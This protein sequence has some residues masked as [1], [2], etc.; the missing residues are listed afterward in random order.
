MTSQNHVVFLNGL[1]QATIVLIG[2]VLRA[3]DD[4]IVAPAPPNTERIQARPVKA[5]VLG[6]RKPQTKEELDRFF[7]NKYLKASTNEEECRQE[8]KQKFQS[9]LEDVISFL[10]RLCH[11]SERQ[12]QN[13][14]LAGQSDQKH[15]FNQYTIARAEFR[16]DRSS[17]EEEAALI[18]SLRE[19]LVAGLHCNGSFFEKYVHRTLSEEQLEKLSQRRRS[20]R[21]YSIDRAISYVEGIVELR[22][23]QREALAAL[24]LNEIPYS[25]DFHNSGP[26]LGNSERMALMYQLSLIGEQKVRP[27]LD[28]EQWK[29]LE[30]QLPEFELA[31][32]QTLAERALISLRWD[33]FADLRDQ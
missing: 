14:L 21:V 17:T 1:L 5:I 11:L 30:A 27:F 16:I 9:E 15:F 31:Y 24:M 20:N 23:S 29:R 12:K 3:D 10:D 28:P 4:I 18:E 8:F 33:K 2:T 6:I 19:Q 26:L 13:L 32:K 7:A 25:A 22:A